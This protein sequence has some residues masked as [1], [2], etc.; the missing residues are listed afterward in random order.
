M[1]ETGLPG[2]PKNQAFGNRPKAKGLP[3]LMAS[4]QKPI[5]PSSS[6][7]CL[8][9]SASPPRLPGGDQGIGLAVGLQEGGA[10]GRRI[11]GDDAK[12]Q[13][14]TAHAVQHRL[15]PVAVGVV[16][17]PVL[18]KGAQRLEL[19]PCAEDGDP[20]GTAHRDV[21]DAR[22]ASSGSSLGFRR[23]PLSS[24]LAFCARSS[25]RRRMFWPAT[26]RV[27]KVI[28]LSPALRFFL[29]HHCVRTQGTGARS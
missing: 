2:R 26:G 28:P 10:K 5:S 20:E 25:P 22:E 24:T 17:V 16:D 13:A 3:G 14:L 23:R 7:S 15:D 9:K 1:A 29:H 21:R 19:V 4:F 27:R 8:V 12:V 18:G 11:V 6:S